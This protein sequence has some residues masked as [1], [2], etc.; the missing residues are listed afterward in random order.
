MLNGDGRPGREGALLSRGASRLARIFAVAI[1][2]DAGSLT[3]FL[4]MGA[5]RFAVAAL[6]GGNSR[7][8][9]GTRAAEA[10]INFACKSGM[11]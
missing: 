8:S 7:F 1:N 9:T 4:F 2:D 5:V 6:N 3:A 10:A 11:A